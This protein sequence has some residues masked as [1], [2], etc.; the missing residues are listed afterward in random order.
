MPDS[1]MVLPVIFIDEETI[2]I[3]EL[4]KLNLTFQKLM[5]V[6]LK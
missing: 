2:A 3:S 6:A 4:Y 1:L 5:Y